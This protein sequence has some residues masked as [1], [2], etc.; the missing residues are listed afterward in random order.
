VDEA[1]TIGSV[2]ALLLLCHF[3]LQPAVA[4]WPRLSYVRHG[5]ARNAP[6]H[7]LAPEPFVEYA[8]WWHEFTRVTHAVIH[9]PSGF[10]AHV[11]GNVVLIVTAAWILLGFLTALGKRRWFSF[12][13][14]ELVV[15]APIVGSYAFDIFGTTAHGYGASTV[16]FAF[17]GLVFVVGLLLLAD[18]VHGYVR[19]RADPT[20]RLSTDGG[21]V[22][23][24]VAVLCL[25]T[26]VGL[27][28][29]ADLLAGS[30]AT[31]V[32]Q[33]GAG[34]GMLVGTV[35]VPLTRRL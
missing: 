12:F 22:V 3:L 34:F 35:F 9:D 18:H 4:A 11:V 17:L 25:V 10:H 14:W 32:H 26:V 16:G 31:P 19:R 1:T 21:E 33:A 5:V 29:A 15:V 7:R 6:A 24:P 8:W 23:D 20:R 28:V 27:V 30:P 2:P 13:Y